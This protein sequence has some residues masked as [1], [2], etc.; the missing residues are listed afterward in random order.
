MGLDPHLYLYDLQ[1]GFPVDHE[2]AQH[3]IGNAYFGSYLY[4]HSPWIEQLFTYLIPLTGGTLDEDHSWGEGEDEMF[5]RAELE[6]FFEELKSVP[7]PSAD[8][9]FLVWNYDHLMLLVATALSKPNL[10][11]TRVIY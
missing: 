1:A 5:G 11:L 8:D 10:T 7:R 6:R 9:A 2:H 4:K 3:N